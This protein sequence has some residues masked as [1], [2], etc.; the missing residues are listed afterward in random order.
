MKY[1]IPKL[2]KIS[3]ESGNM[4]LIANYLLK[5]EGDLS[6]LKVKEI[7]EE[8]YISVASATRLAKYMGLNGFS[9]LKTYLAI[10]K[11][12]L[13]M[14]NMQNQAGNINGYY[15][16]VSNYLEKT[17]NYVDGK[18]ILECARIIANA[19]KVIL[20]GSGVDNLFL[21]LFAFKLKTLNINVQ[22][23]IDSQLQYID[24][25][26]STNLDVC[27]V[28]N[29]NQEVNGLI[30]NLQTIQANGTQTIG[31]INCDNEIDSYFD[32]VLILNTQ[33]FQTEKY[34]WQSS[35]GVNVMCELLCLNIMEIKKGT[36]TLSRHYT[37]E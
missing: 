23:Q 27:I 12:E 31:M 2:E 13:A 3:L 6:E 32:N 36:I 7:C 17:L 29:T 9:E 19:Q 26:N 5:Y 25:Q 22:F 28:L 18:V 37:I 10:E 8:L 20:L 34:N 24:C 16:L 21:Q 33:D 4:A 14:S 1:I 30:S 11:E 15:N 35:V